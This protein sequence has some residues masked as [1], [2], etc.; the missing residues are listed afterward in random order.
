MSG[1][2]TIA[3]YDPRRLS[4]E[5]FLAGFVAREELVEFLLAQLRLSLDGEAR[6]RLILGQRG[7]G[8]T[9]LLRRLQIGIRDDPT[10]SA[11]LLPLTFREEQYNVRSADRFW[12]NCGEALAEALENEGDAEA[13]AL[14][15]AELE[16][17]DWREPGRA[18][19]AF[20]ARMAATGRRAVLLVDNLD[21]ILNSIP[22][23]QHWHLRRALQAHGGPI[24]I[25][26]ATQLPGQIGDH[27]AAFYEFF[28]WD[29]LEP[30]N[31]DEMFAC[32]RRLA[33]ANPESGAPVLRAIRTQPERLRV[34]HTL[35]GGNP[36]ILVLLYGLLERAD[37]DTAHSDLEGLLDQVTP[38]Y[39]ARVEELRSD[40]QRAVF[41]A[42]ALNWDPITSHRLSVVTGVEITSLPSILAKLREFGLI[43]EVQTSGA[44]AGFQLCERF[45]NVW[46]LMRHGT[47]RTR[48]RVR[49]LTAFLE[50]F[51]SV[52]EIRELFGR[53]ADKGISDEWASLLKTALLD[54]IERAYPDEVPNT[55]LLPIDLLQIMDKAGP[56]ARLVKAATAKIANRDPAYFRD[57]PSVVAALAAL[58][59]DGIGERERADEAT[60]LAISLE[61]K[62]DTMMLLGFHFMRAGGDHELAE[63]VFRLVLRG[64]AG[65]SDVHAALVSLC[66]MTERFDEARLHRSGLK[67]EDSVFAPLADATLELAA[68]NVGNA[69][70]FLATALNEGNPFQTVSTVGVYACLLRLFHQRGQGERIIDWF[71]E[72]GHAD[73]EAPLYA[74]LVAYVRGARSLLDVNPEVRAPGELMFLLIAG[75][76][77]R[78]VHESRPGGGRGSNGPAGRAAKSRRSARKASLKSDP[79]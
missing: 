24:L 21:L 44:R 4:R 72:S 70:K 8:K 52:D 57:N 14:L 45:F 73:K 12:R 41:D 64:D 58:L 10:L 31:K 1:M 47:R 54:A 26:A 65:R 76:P 63:A 51:Y 53:L 48:Q 62:F 35:T 17:G 40:L 55:D 34:L 59:F 38:L 69:I 3:I 79:N 16:A 46:Y 7:L 61:L 42:I 50:T 20:A 22:A 29:L 27:E 39:K 56:A 15:D 66:V 78:S 18:G 32:L 11:G 9:S 37:S 71:I 68:N 2:T 30:L 28:Q 5:D 67:D 19:D 36:R 43:E 77:L 60:R 74:A 33:E 23:D 49:W 13:A 25:A 75:S 6:H